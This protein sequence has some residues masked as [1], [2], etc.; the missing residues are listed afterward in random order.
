MFTDVGKYAFI[1]AKLRARIGKLL[2]EDYFSRLLRC[3][4][5]AEMFN[6]L[7]NGPFSDLPEI[8][9][10]TGDLKTVELELL[11][12]ES[13]IL[14][15]IEPHLPAD[16]LPLARAFT[17]GYEIENLKNALHFFFDYRYRKRP[18]EHSVHYLL[19]QPL[20][21]EIP[22]DAIINSS[23]FDE[24]AEQLS[25]TPYCAVILN[26]I[27]EVERLQSVFPM[28]IALDRYYYRHLLDEACKLSPHDKSIAVRLIGAEIDLHNINWIIRFRT[29]YNLSFD[30]A[31]GLI[32]PGGFAVK[33]DTLQDV[34]R[35]QY[36]NAP[37]VAMLKKNYPAIA[38]LMT[39]Q[40]QELQQRLSF[41]ESIL[42]HIMLE[43]V[44]RIMRGYPFTIGIIIAYY[45]LKKLEIKRIR[46]SLNAAY[47]HISSERT[48]SLL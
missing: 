16:A 11:K 3:P 6:F 26:E 18:V 7:R 39:Q 47:Y 25:P 21:H 35:S 4:S 45:M 36:M 34:Y 14:S 1:N 15:D 28:S 42:E 20:L 31:A 17:T 10:R 40:P 48:A 38:P 32:I 12:K 41:L 29:F 2:S 24:I 44:H 13:V 27:A 46:C 22:V 43:E 30:E 23:S 8:Y 9:D 19:H 37:L 5:L 33:G